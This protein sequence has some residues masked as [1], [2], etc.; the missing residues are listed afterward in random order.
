MFSEAEV[1]SIVSHMNEDHA[2]AVELYLRAFGGVL[3][4]TAV[5]LTSIDANGMQ[6]AYQGNGAEQIARVPFDPPLADASEV[7]TRLVTMV[8]EARKTLSD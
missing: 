1:E 4:A 7:R 8:N 3:E 6:I 5:S 2:D